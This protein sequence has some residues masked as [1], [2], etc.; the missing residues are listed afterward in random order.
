MK[1]NLMIVFLFSIIF[2][3]CDK[4]SNSSD[5]GPIENPWTKSDYWSYDDWTKFGNAPYTL[6]WAARKRMW[7]SSEYYDVSQGIERGTNP[8]K[9]IKMVDI[10]Y[11][12]S[13]TIAHV[14]TILTIDYDNN[15][16]IDS[17]NSYKYHFSGSRLDSALTSDRNV[18][19]YSGD[20]LQKLIIH[21]SYGHKGLYNHRY[22]DDHIEIITEI[23]SI[24][25]P[26][27]F[28]PF[29]STVLM[30]DPTLNMVTSIESWRYDESSG[31]WSETP[32]IK[33]EIYEYN[34]IGKLTARYFDGSSNTSKYTYNTENK[35]DSA[36]FRD[37]VVY[38]ASYNEQ[39]SISN[40][41]RKGFSKTEF[42]YDSLTN[43]PK[44]RIK[45]DYDSLTSDWLI[46]EK[47]QIIIE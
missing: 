19:T 15:G 46:I 45:Y 32:F 1:Q 21:F 27:N 25:E 44:E 22:E 24:E 13:G 29:D 35:L 23:S 26:D 43:Y 28:S 39:G 41:T 34:S 8:G 36:I 17:W 42:S 16:R 6:Y 9:T 4:V 2:I 30:L 31:N 5:S 14:D 33:K 11:S 47:R 40:Y 10:E 38:T 3:S 7:P 18:F 12:D 20:K 37:T